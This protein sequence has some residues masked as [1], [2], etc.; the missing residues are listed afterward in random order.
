LTRFRTVIALAAML[1]LTLAFAAC[2]GGSDDPQTV[3][4]EATLQGVE[5]AEIEMAL[6]IDVKG[7]EG[8]HLDV[9]VSG[10]FESEDEAE[11]PEFDLTATAKGNIG[12]E[13][14]DFDGGLTLLGD[15]AY[16][17]YEKVEY[18]VDPS[19]FS[20]VRS[21][22]KQQTGTE[23]KSGEVTACQEAAAEVKLSDFVENL[24]DGGSADVGGADTTK[25]SGDL[26]VGGTID[27]AIELSEDPACSEQLQATDSLPSVA[28]LE[29][30]QG[31]V[32]QAVESAHVDL[33]VGDDHI[34]RRISTQA[35]IE[36]PKKGSGGGAKSVDLEFD[37]TLT[38]VNEEQTIAAPSGSKPLSALFVKLG[39]NPLELLGLLQ[40]R[41]E[42]LQGPGGIEE[43]LKGIGSG[44]FQ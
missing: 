4:D 20:F 43:L 33:Y 26:D 37:L 32:E 16:V 17:A 5:S 41:G 28:Q 7:S 10:P 19:T 29:K 13:K 39:I 36:P 31:E 6:G 21:L 11:L 14:V 42:A 40:R 15:K 34:V 22:L 9:S 23:G 25:V 30:A 3:V 27:A 2:G 1:A 18:E 12:G 24:K 35:T 44:G 8:G 38:G